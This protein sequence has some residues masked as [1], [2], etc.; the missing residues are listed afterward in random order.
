MQKKSE[1]EKL[2][3]K[4]SANILSFYYYPTCKYVWN[5]NIIQYEYMFNILRQIGG[6]HVEGL[7]WASNPP[8]WTNE[9]PNHLK[10]TLIAM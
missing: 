3:H 7:D 10:Q 5:M 4:N 1:K 2:T 8:R 9:L 6:I